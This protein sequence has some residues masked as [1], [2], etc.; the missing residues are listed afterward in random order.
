M[1]SYF[2]NL[3]LRGVNGGF[4]RN[5]SQMNKFPRYIVV[6]SLVSGLFFSCAG[7]PRVR[8]EEPL[9]ERPGAS[10]PPLETPREFPGISPIEEA[11]NKVKDQSGEIQ[12]YF[13]ADS[14]SLITVKADIGEFTVIYDLENALPLDETRFRVDFL[15]EDPRNGDTR[16]D[17]LLWTIGEDSAGILLAFDDDY[18]AVW[19]QYFDLFD[20]YGAKA[21]FFVT[22]DFC[23]FCREALN[24][25]HD[26][27]YHTRHHLNL[28]KLSRDEFFEETLSALDMFRREGIPV[29]SFA[30]P[31]GFWEPWMHEELSGH[32]TTLRGFGTTFRVYHGE[33]LRGGYVSSKSLDNTI[34]KDDADFDRAVG[35]MFRIVK[36]I[37]GDTVVPLTT[38]TIA[39]D[40]AWGIKPQRLE[41]I[42]KTARDLRLRFYRYS[43]F[44]P[45][46]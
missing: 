27:G 7:Q 2:R 41:Y 12:K 15:V 31:Y 44:A 38:H 17:S 24:R 36:F 40:A 18:Q 11:V 14:D 46:L 29:S 39:D 22:G 37:G 45:D 28:L 9:E 42:L 35:L 16:Q 13:L 5:L 8:I 25:G 26:V 33:D 20:R 4:L 32:F 3:N 1:V 21:T 10:P 34:Y 43:D 30:Y 6:L 23:A 19:E